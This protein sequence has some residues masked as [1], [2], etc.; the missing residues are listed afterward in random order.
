MENKKI[1]A[2]LGIARKAGKTASGETGA[3]A[4]VKSGEAK[5]LLVSADAS[6]NTK[7]KFYDKCTYRSIPIYLFGK[8]EELGHAIGKEMCASLAI[9]DSGLAEALVKQIRLNGGSEYEG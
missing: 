5:L 1:L 4:A 6:A 7:K 3:E 2:L 9:L 8:K